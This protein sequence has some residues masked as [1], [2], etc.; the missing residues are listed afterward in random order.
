MQTLLDLGANVLH[1]VTTEDPMQKPLYQIE[2]A[3]QKGHL[4]L[5]VNVLKRPHHIAI[6]TPPPVVIPAPVGWSRVEIPDH[7]GI[8]H[9]YLFDTRGNYRREHQPYRRQKQDFS[10][11]G[12]LLEE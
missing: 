10:D 8:N 7:E 3:N 11:I 4:R 1:R 12:D 6:N 2:V 9:K 5:A